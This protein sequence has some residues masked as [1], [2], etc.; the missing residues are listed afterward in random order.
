MKL[1]RRR[2]LSSSAEW[3][4][5]LKVPDLLERGQKNKRLHQEKK[6]KRAHQERKRKKDNKVTPG[7]GILGL[8]VTTPPPPGVAGNR[9]NLPVITSSIGSTSANA[10]IHSQVYSGASGIA[11]ISEYQ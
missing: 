9:H 4:D 10:S 7:P 5:E 6:K 2:K 3:G 11:M 8:I 1:E